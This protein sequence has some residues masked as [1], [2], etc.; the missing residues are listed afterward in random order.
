MNLPRNSKGL[1]L[2]LS[3][4]GEIQVAGSFEDDSK[5]S[6]SISLL[7]EALTASQEALCSVQLEFALFIT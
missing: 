3:G 2:N 5:T 4:S 6:I 7:A 1:G